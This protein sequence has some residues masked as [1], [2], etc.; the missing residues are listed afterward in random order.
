MTEDEIPPLISPKQQGLEETEIR[1]V[2]QDTLPPLIAPRPKDS[3][4]LEI[5]SV[6]Q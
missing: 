6:D 3:E 2:T 4:M 5:A 1:Y